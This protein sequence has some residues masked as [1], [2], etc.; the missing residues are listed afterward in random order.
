[1]MKIGAVLLVL[2]MS[3]VAPMS[4]G[5][6]QLSSNETYN[7]IG[8]ALLAY[9]AVAQACDHRQLRDLKTTVV[10]YLEFLNRKDAL[11]RA[12]RS[13]YRNAT[14]AI[15]RGVREF[16]RRPYVT[17]G[18]APRYYANLMASAREAIRSG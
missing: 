13:I 5:A 12:G 7:Q 8:E 1:M 18:E 16:Q 10:Q 4:V 6:Q 3:A 15:E 9:T 2:L 11:T 14:G 17:C